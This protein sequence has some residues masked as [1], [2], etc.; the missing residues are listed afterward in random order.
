MKNNSIRVF[1]FSWN[2]IGSNSE[3]TALLCSIIKEKDLLVHV[4]FSH[5]DFTPNECIQ[6]AKVLD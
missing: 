6:I 4:S 1:D 5:N 2:N 3:V